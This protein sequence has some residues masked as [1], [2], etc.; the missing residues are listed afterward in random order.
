MK[1]GAVTTKGSPGV[2]RKGVSKK[3]YRPLK[4]IKPPEPVV[5]ERKYFPRQLEKGWTKRTLMHELARMEKTQTKLAEEHNVTVSAINQ[6]KTRHA[7]EIQELKN[8]IE[9]QFAGLWITKKENRLAEYQ[10]A[11][12][13][14]ENELEGG[15]MDVDYVK[16]KIKILKSVAE[17]MGHLPSRTTVQVQTTPVVY[18]VHGVNIEAMK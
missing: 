5:E 4:P 6:F 3:G 14:I 9:D 11:F 2:V 10:Q 1:G 15:G 8:K 7:T 16:A 17:E 18:Q 12:E 13:D